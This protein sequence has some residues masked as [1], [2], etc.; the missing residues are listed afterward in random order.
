MTYHRHQRTLKR[1]LIPD[2]DA[3]ENE[4]KMA[5]A[6]ISNE[7]FEVS[8]AEGQDRAV[9]NARDSQ[10]DGNRSE[11]LSRIRKQ[12]NDEPH[13]SIRSC[14]QQKSGKN[15]APCCWGLGVRIGQ[16]RMKGKRWQLD[17]ECNEETQHDPHLRLWRH[18]G[19]KQ[20]R[21]LE[22]VD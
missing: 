5:H 12:R 7:A 14:L 4:T 9:E 18:C 13:H 11:R 3:Y 8:L 1:E 22:R 19:M 6:G 15:N 21:V 2:K 17:R 10:A 16:P 20:V